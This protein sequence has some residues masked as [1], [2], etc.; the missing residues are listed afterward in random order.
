[1]WGKGLISCFMFLI[2]QQYKI[3][4]MYSE[5]EKWL[6]K[7]FQ[8]KKCQIPVDFHLNFSI[9]LPFGPHSQ[10][11]KLNPKP[12]CQSP[13][14]PPP[15][16]PITSLCT[17]LPAVLWRFKAPHPSIWVPRLRLLPSGF[18]RSVL[19]SGSEGLCSDQEGSHVVRMSSFSLR[20]PLAFSLPTG[21]SAR[22]PRAPWELPGWPQPLAA[23]HLTNPR[24]CY[25]V[26]LVLTVTE[27][28]KLRLPSC[29]LVSSVPAMCSLTLKLLSLFV[30]L[31]TYGF[32]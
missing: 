16:P 32:F 21:I 6:K 29:G 4:S 25:A 9:Y 7:N 27:P 30:E 26:K 23:P 11:V 17:T 14:S 28:G 15:A 20:R 8:G 12:S 31:S 13:L 24:G 18:L 19:L 5:L 10:T 22:G 2:I 1:M 3:H